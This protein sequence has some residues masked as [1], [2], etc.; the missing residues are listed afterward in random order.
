[1]L[2]SCRVWKNLG[3]SGV[4]GLYFATPPLTL[5]FHVKSPLPEDEAGLKA[6]RRKLSRYNPQQY[7]VE[8]MPVTYDFGQLWRWNVTLN[9]F[10]LSA[11]NTVGIVRAKVDLNYSVYGDSRDVWMNGAEPSS[12]S[13]YSDVCNILQVFVLDTD[14]AVAAFPEL[15]PQLGI[16]I[17]AVGLVVPMSGKPIRVSLLWV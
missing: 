13:G 16:P 5:Y 4:T 10:S 6:L 17:D 3:D 15:L 12:L 2:P 9:R 11:G 14:A 8:I 1:M 7:A